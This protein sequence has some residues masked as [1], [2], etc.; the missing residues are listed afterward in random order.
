MGIVKTLQVLAGAFVAGAALLVIAKGQSVFVVALVG[1]S[2]A[3]LL[4]AAATGLHYLHRIAEAIEW[5]ALRG[6]RPD[7]PLCPPPH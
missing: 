2:H 1:A 6:T 7:E 4:W 5:T 3:A